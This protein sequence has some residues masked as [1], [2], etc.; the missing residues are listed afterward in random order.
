[1]ALKDHWTTIPPRKRL[2]RAMFIDPLK[3]ATLKI[4]TLTILLQEARNGL[5]TA[6]LLLAESNKA[7][8]AFAKFKRLGMKINSALKT[9]ADR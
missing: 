9:G 2:S 7:D 1:M 8:E 4:A 6:F 3:A 5:N